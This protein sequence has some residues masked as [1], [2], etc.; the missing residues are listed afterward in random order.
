MPIYAHLESG[1]EAADLELGIVGGVQQKRSRR[2]R[3]LSTRFYSLGRRM[4]RSMTRQ[5]QT[6][7]KHRP[8]FILVASFAFLLLCI[9][10]F[11]GRMHSDGGVSA[12]INRYRSEVAESVNLYSNLH[13]LVMVAGHAI[14]TSGGKGCGEVEGEESWYLESYQKHEGQA[15]TFVQ[16][17]KIGV[18]VAAEDEKSLLVFSGGETRKQA[19]PRSEAQSYWGV[20]ESKD[21]FGKQ[22]QVRERAM[23]EEHARDSFENLL[24]S[25]CRFRELTG[26]YPL[27]ITVVSYDFK[28]FRFA[29]LHRAALHFPASRFTF[30]GTPSAPASI[31]AAEKAELLVQ[32]SFE[33]DPYGCEGPLREKRVKRDPFLRTIPYPV[34]CPEISGLFSYCGTELYSKRLPWDE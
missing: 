23:T 9:I 17:I 34:G 31:L 22:E 29:N 26:A 12:G 2:K 24:F 21:W 15:A 11:L 7:H 10:L 14:Y 18:Q 5:L 13:N 27:N 28:K 4:F 1:S 19:G 33:R 8:L 20:A 30:K 32:D 3:L 25:V 6:H 16:H